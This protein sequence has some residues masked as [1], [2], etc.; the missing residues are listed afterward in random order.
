MPGELT[1]SKRLRRLRVDLEEPAPAGPRVL[2][3]GVVAAAAIGFTLLGAGNL[4]LGPLEARLGIASGERLGP[5]GRAF[6]GWE[7]GLWPGT[8]APCW[9]WT[10]GLGGTPT[11][12]SVRWPTA[13]AA[14]AIGLI[15]ARR[16]G[17]A[18]GEGA[19]A[20]GAVAWFGSL[21]MIDRSGPLATGMIAGMAIVGALDRILA[22]GSDWGAGLWAALAVLAG[23]WPALL[24]IA[25]PVIV[26]GRKGRW[27][28]AGLVVPP[29]V[30]LAGWSAWA[31][32]VARVDV[33]AAGLTWPLTQGSSWL[34]AANV[35]ALSLPWGPFAALVAWP[36]VRK[37]WTG[38]ARELVVAWLKLTVAALLVGTVV[39]GM[40]VAALPAALA[41]LALA[42][43]AACARAWEGEL[44][45][46]PRRSV[47]AI[48]TAFGLIWAVV[49]TPTAINVA[50][51]VPF[52]RTVVIPVALTA[53]LIGF[54]ALDAAW[55]GS[56]R[57]SLLATLA[58]AACLKLGHWGVY[59]PEWDYRIGQGPWGR[60]IGQWVPPRWPIYTV[61][62]WPADLAFA[63]GHPF[64]ILANPLVLEHQGKG[65]GRPKFVLLHAEEFENWPRSAPRLVKVRAFRD[66]HDQAR[67][68]ARTEGELVRDRQGESED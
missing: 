66:Q 25:L 9:L 37:G 48:A 67:V 4:D 12:A 19:E 42:A 46:G 68:L 27:L 44:A 26:D 28:S 34:L 1:T 50:A 45:K 29:L 36:M 21:A 53:P 47:L 43:G 65:D 40:A 58:L 38:P 56:S 52:Y 15:L 16:L 57:R 35:A 62:H 41:G 24:I 3:R 60:A 20:W 64:R 63:T 5:L 31:L 7:P 14:V 22:R 18:L 13:I 11:P 61:L 32:S 54:A 2:A 39:P 8:V 10:K 49:V 30:A 17:R 55:S 23:G 51:A 59:V 6:G 33:W